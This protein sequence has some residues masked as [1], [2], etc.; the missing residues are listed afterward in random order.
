M[1]QPF[2]ASQ[3]PGIQRTTP[4]PESVDIYLDSVPYTAAAV[5]HE[6]YLATEDR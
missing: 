2:R 6:L 3:R 1:G 4:S 5:D